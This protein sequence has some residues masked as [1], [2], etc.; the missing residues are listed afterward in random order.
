MACKSASIHFAWQCFLKSPK[1]DDYWW[2]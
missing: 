2:L 1:S